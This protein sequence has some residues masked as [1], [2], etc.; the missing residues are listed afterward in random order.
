MK[1]PPWPK[2]ANYLQAH[3]DPDGLLFY[4]GAWID[5][6][7]L[8]LFAAHG[9]Y[10]RVVYC[11]YLLSSE[12]VAA[13]MNRIPGWQACDAPRE[14]TPAEYGAASWADLWPANEYARN[15][16][17]PDGPFGLR[18]AL[19][20]ENGQR[21]TLDYLGTEAIATYHR[22][23][24]IR[25]PP[26]AIVLQDHGYGCN[27][28]RFGGW[29]GRCAFAAALGA[30]HPHDPSAG[31]PLL[32]FTAQYTSPWPGYSRVTR[33]LG[34]DGAMHRD[35]RA[36]FARDIQ[37]READHG[38]YRAGRTQMLSGGR[39]ERAG[40]GNRPGGG[41]SDSRPVGI[42]VRVLTGPAFGANS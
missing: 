27:W 13:F 7:P 39:N 40:C 25:Q 42:G 19:I 35:K 23:C 9:G 32:A 8:R 33:F 5:H 34:Y 28:T 29:E 36:M 41:A 15:H 16:Q 22:L 4:P 6:G 37:V 3:P 17:S 31:L 38:H 11:D 12:Q 10:R 24:A 2:P 1:Q 21:V 18:A 14:L 20:G 30:M 26:T